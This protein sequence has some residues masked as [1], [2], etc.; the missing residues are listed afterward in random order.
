VQTN[1]TKP[2]QME[3]MKKFSGSWKHDNP[4]TAVIKFHFE[5][6]SPDIFILT[7]IQN[8]IIVNELP[9]NREK[10]RFQNLN[11]DQLLTQSKLLTK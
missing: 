2:N 3:L 6:K 7:Y 8:N 10:H 9:W 1:G 11:S 5:F 4:E